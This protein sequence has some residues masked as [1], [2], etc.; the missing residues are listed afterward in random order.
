MNSVILGNLYF[1]KKHNFTSYSKNNLLQL[2]DL[3]IQLNQILP[4]KGKKCFHTKNLPKTALI[5]TQK[6]QIVAQTQ[7]L[8]E[9]SLAKSSDQYQSFTGLV[10]PSNHLKDKCKPVPTW[11]LSKLDDTDKVFVSA[12]NLSDNQIRLNNQTELEHFEFLNETQADNLIEIDPQLFLLPK[13]RNADDFEG[14]LNQLIQG[15]HFEKIDTPNG[16]P[17]P[18]Y[19]KHSFPSPETCIDFS[20]VTPLQRDNYDHILQLQKKNWFLKTMKPIKRTF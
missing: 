6:V 11:S 3:T 17:H 16:R 20:I 13:M 8:L 15:F 7:V 12:I 19:S 1:L 5:L 10:I 2:R 18:D 9:C 4:Q 14:E